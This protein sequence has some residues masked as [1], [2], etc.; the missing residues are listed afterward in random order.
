MQRLFLQKLLDIQAEQAG[1]NVLDV[2][3]AG[4]GDGHTFV[5]RLLVSQALPTTW[6]ATSPS[7]S[8]ISG[9]TQANLSNV[10]AAFWMGS[11]AEA[12]E[13][14]QEAAI[15]SIRLPNSDLQQVAVGHAGAA[16]GTR[17]MAFMAGV[18]VAS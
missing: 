4:G 17:F 3:I 9:W 18:N 1:L 12:L 5:V 10:K 14:Y 2:D 11:D 16:K 8:V 13:S 15:A 7:G 6:T